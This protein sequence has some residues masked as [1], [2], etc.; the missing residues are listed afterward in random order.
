M[1]PGIS[2]DEPDDDSGRYGSMR[3][4]DRFSVQ[5]RCS[6]FSSGRLGFVYERSRILRLSC[7][8]ISTMRI[9][10]CGLYA[11][12]P[13]SISPISLRLPSDEASVTLP[14]S[15]ALLSFPSS[16]TCYLPSERCRTSSR[17][18]DMGREEQAYG[19]FLLLFS[20]S[21]TPFL[22]SHCI[23]LF[24]LLPLVSLAIYLLNHAIR[25]VFR[26]PLSVL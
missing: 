1:E 24:L 8:L 17:Y 13:M 26:I 12:T 2:R 18:V 4:F 23:L 7:S 25:T 19:Q 9:R 22:L 11:H 14:Y 21:N 10:S 5:Y 20:D 6:L 3:L 16:L 15:I